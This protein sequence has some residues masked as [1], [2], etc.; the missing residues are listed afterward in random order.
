MNYMKPLRN[1]L[2]V[3]ETLWNVMEA[4]RSNEALWERYGTLRERC[5]SLQNV[6]ASYKKIAIVI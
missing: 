4:L 5:G 2:G 1:V 3:T 6:I